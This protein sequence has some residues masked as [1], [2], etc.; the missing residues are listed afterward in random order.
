M[1]ELRFQVSTLVGGTMFRKPEISGTCTVLCMYFVPVFGPNR[2]CR[3]YETLMFWRQ[4]VCCVSW[5]ICQCSGIWLENSWQKCEKWWDC[6]CGGLAR[7]SCRCP[8]EVFPV[9]RRRMLLMWLLRWSSCWSAAVTATLAYVQILWWHLTPR[10]R[11]PDS[12]CT[13]RCFDCQSVIPYSPM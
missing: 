12:T 13:E 10:S 8:C 5:T 11:C 9:S 3:W 1:P 6:W 4:F 7:T 2:E